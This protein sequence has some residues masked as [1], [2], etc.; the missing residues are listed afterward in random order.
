M[1]LLQAA[2]KV[3]GKKK[4]GRIVNISSVVGVTGN[5]GQANYSAAK[6]QAAVFPLALL[7]YGMPFWLG[8]FCQ[9]LDIFR[10]RNAEGC[11]LLH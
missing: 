9:S 4:K 1:T 8:S 7:R 10:A 3:M 11:T 2:T 6:V 5:A